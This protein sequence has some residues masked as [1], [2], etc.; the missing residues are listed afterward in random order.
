VPDGYPRRS[1]LDASVHFVVQTFVFRTASADRPA[2]GDG[3][4]AIST[5]RP[6]DQP[7]SLL[8]DLQSLN[9]GASLTNVA[10][11]A[12]NFVA[13]TAMPA[14]GADF[15]KSSWV[16]LDSEGCFDLMHAQWPFRK[17]MGP[18]QTEPPMVT[19][20]PLRHN[21]MAPRTLAAFLSRFP[22]LGP[23]LW[24]EASILLAAKSPTLLKRP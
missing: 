6:H 8:V 23:S 18:P 20:A 22:E 4:L 15:S 14:L 11:R 10:D 5:F 1:S 17:R 24:H 12:I 2:P 7:L 16:E 19:F 9:R 3:I 21:D 13:Q